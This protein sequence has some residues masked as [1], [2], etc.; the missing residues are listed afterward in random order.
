MAP[1][2]SLKDKLIDDSNIVALQALRDNLAGRL[3]GATDRDAKAIS[4][5]LR[6]VYK[7]LAEARKAA[8]TTPGS[9]NASEENEVAAARARR[10]QRVGRA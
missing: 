7:D 2:K 9:D 4:I 10:E 8:D 3:A 5:E 6:Q 1:R